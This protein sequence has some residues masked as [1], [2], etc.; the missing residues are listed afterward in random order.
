M[1]RLP[2][3]MYYSGIKSIGLWEKRGVRRINKGLT[4]K[5]GLTACS[6]LGIRG[7]VKTKKPGLG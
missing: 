7:S 2:L 4:K 5:T 6:A 1:V 3:L